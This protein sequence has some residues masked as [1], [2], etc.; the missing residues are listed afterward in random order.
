MPSPSLR[1]LNVVEAPAEVAR[2]SPATGALPVAS[3]AKEPCLECDSRC[4]RMRVVVNVVEALRISAALG[5]PLSS[6]VDVA[7]HTPD[8]TTTY[9]WPFKLDDGRHVFLFR[10]GATGHCVH[11][12]RPGSTTS[13]C[14]IYELRAANCRLYPFTLEDEIGR[15]PAGSQEHCPVQWLQDEGTRARAADDVR[16]YREDQQLDRAIVRFWN[17]GRRT[18]SLAVFV[19]WLTGHVAGELGHDVERL[20]RV[21]AGARR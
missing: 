18:R 10:R 11:L 21:H 1:I 13:R 17:R 3:F 15:I 14:G 2:I 4:C 6:F 20:Q 12:A 16:R 19:D 7:P 8:L 5:L 9:A